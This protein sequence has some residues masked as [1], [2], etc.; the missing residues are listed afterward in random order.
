MGRHSAPDDEELSS[1]DTTVLVVTE[2]GAGDGQ[3]AGRH[4]TAATDGAAEDGAAQ[5]T[6][7]IVQPKPAPEPEETGTH[8]DLRLLRENRALRA[9]CAAAVVVPFLIY[10]IVLVVVA[11]VDLYLLWMWIPTVTAGVLVGSFLDLEHRRRK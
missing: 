6:A 3:A 5:P 11:R 2:A 9:R 10:T 1:A 8:A 4:H 7:P